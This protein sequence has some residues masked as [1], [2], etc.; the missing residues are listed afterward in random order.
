MDRY[1]EALARFGHHLG[2]AFQIADDILDYTGTEKVT[3]KPA[4]HDLRER[5]VTLPLVAALESASA[6]ETKAIQSFFTLVDPSDQEIED[7]VEIV[8][9]RGGIHFARSRAEHFALL[10]SEALEGLPEGPAL[11]SLRASILYSIDRSR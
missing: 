8:G 1:R 9:R 7:I 6:V 4:G 3:G 11:R 10:A 5:K 2:M